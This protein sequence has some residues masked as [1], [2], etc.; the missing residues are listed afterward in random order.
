M[1]ALTAN[2]ACSTPVW[3]GRQPIVDSRKRLVAYEVLYRSGT[4]SEAAFQDG[5]QATSAVLLNTFVELG[6]DQVV[7]D[8]VAF[9]NFTRE[10]LTGAYPL[11]EC[12]KRLVLEVLEDI[13]PDEELIQSLKQRRYEGYKIALD[14]FVHHPRLEPL[15]D[16]AT[17]V[18]VDLRNIPREDWPNHVQ[19]LRK[20]PLRLLAE[21]VETLEEFECCKSLGFDLFQ[22]FFLARPEIIE[23]RR[24]DCNQMALMRVIAEIN[25][26]KS[27]IGRLSRIVEQDPALCI[28]LLRY[29]NSSHFGIR[30]KVKTLQHACAMLGL[31]AIR[32]ITTLLMLAGNPHVP[33]QAAKDALLRAWMCRSLAENLNAPDAHS[34]FTVGLLSMLDVL[35]GKPLEE[36]LA[37]L[38]IEDSITEAILH[39]RGLP[40]QVLR[41]VVSY[42]KC[43]WDDLTKNGANADRMRTAYLESLKQVKQ[44]WAAAS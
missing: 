39:G 33:Q 2:P 36:S 19:R 23:G 40:G 13:E 41:L 18:K 26:P 17:I 14:D 3:L 15:L 8:R 5:N 25:S 20:K 7:E 27:D 22:G 37:Q 28:K 44:A 6:I 42:E 30:Q 1:S 34:L 31:E 29:V 43:E 10:F 21:K 4:E 16:L 11:P 24:L 32:T 38:P 35:L 9:I 12:P